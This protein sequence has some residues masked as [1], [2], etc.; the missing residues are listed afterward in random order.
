MI[1]AAASDNK[2]DT[3]TRILDAAEKLFGEKGFDATSLRDITTEAQ[4]N[5]AAVNYHFQSK[6]SLIDAVIE[7]RLLPVTRKRLALLTAAGPEPSLEHI[8]EAFLEPLLHEDMVPAVPLIGRVLAN[9]GWFL[10]R[11]YHK[12]VIEVVQ[13]FREALRIALPHLTEEERLWRLQFMAG[14]VI[15]VLVR[16]SMLPSIIG[17][18]SV[19]IDR[20]LVRANL[21]TF[22]TAGLRAPATTPPTTSV[23]KT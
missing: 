18:P 9:P 23:E 11:V 17:D 15:H 20:K 1:A 3:K 8:V 13:R 6:D 16:S 21:V 2:S 7:R 14:S 12:H 19:L 5:L 22:L 4:V 10:D